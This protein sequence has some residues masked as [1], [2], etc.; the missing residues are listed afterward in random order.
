MP[1]RT[2]VGIS[3]SGFIERGFIQ[4]PICGTKKKK[5]QLHVRCANSKKWRN[6]DACAVMEGKLPVITCFISL[7]M[8][9]LLK[10]YC[11]FTV[12]FVVHINIYNY[13]NAYRFRQ[14]YWTYMHAF[15]SLTF[16]GCSHS[17]FI[18]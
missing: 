17:S 1:L 12:P 6:D 9:I 11:T 2:V 13:A 7:N 5:R 4:F 16:V 15:L 14:E 10:L 8:L 18:F 3:E